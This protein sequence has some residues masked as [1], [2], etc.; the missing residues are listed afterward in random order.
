MGMRVVR[1]QLALMVTNQSAEPKKKCNLV[2]SINYPEH[3]CSLG[4]D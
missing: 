2:S 1:L 4:L 3:G